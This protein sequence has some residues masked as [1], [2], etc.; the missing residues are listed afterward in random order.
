MPCDETF[1]IY[2]SRYIF[3]A[4]DQLIYLVFFCCQTPVTLFI[5][6]VMDQAA[7]SGTCTPALT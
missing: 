1:I 3:G 6:R 7:N 2:H 4:R 5:S